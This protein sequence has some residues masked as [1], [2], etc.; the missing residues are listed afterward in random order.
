M[1]I[2]IL[3]SIADALED[4]HSDGFPR[5]PP[6]VMGMCRNRVEVYEVFHIFSVIFLLYMSLRAI[7]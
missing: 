7:G 5:R 1:Y 4:R 6:L 3:D 2:I